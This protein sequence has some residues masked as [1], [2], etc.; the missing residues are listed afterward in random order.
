MTIGEVCHTS[1]FWIQSQRTATS[2]LLAHAGLIK[3]R[4]RDS[5]ASA[6]IFKSAAVVWS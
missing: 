1:G 3:G 4:I 2:R 6:N 5:W